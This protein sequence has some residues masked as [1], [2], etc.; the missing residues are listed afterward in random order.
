[1]I[2][3]TEP[4][5]RLLSEIVSATWPTSPA[6]IVMPAIPFRE[7]AQA[8]RSHSC[9]LTAGSECHVS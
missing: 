6:K 5:F 8:D 3:A 4:A 9:L 1:M 2:I 7:A